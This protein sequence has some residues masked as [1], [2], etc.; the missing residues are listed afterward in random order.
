MIYHL[1]NGDALA[2]RFDLPDEG[3]VCREALTSGNIQA[4]NVADLWKVRA[5]FIEREFGDT[6]YFEKVVPEFEKL[7][8]ANEDD[9]VNLWFGNDAFCQVNMWFCLS[10]ITGKNLQVYRIFP[11]VGGWNCSFKNLEKCLSRRVGMSADEVKLGENLWKSFQK[12]DAENLLEL[13][14]QGSDGFMR[15]GEVSR[16]L[17][18]INSRPLSILK[19]IK[20]SGEDNFGKIFQRFCEEADIYGF[21]DAQVKML[22]DEV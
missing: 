2:A 13:G 7:Q 18:E 8:N 16:A 3:I 22:L 11:D 21:G 10:L 5:E 4:D 15:L 1:L 14:K 20:S 19:A 6:D 9:E 12:G 17:A